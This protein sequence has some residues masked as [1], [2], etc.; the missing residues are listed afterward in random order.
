MQQHPR[1]PLS[2]NPDKQCKERLDRPFCYVASDSVLLQPA[3]S[4]QRAI[5]GAE[6]LMLS[7]VPSAPLAHAMP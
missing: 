7:D 1:E 5:S 2:S 3:K 4:S 6:H